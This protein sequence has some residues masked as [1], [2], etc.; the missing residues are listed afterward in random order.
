[1]A[2]VEGMSRKTP[3]DWDAIATVAKNRI[4]TTRELDDL[5]VP[6]KTVSDRTDP[7]GPWRRLLPGVIQ[8]S[9]GHLTTEQRYDAAL[10]YGGP[11]AVLTG[12]SAARL[13]GLQHLPEAAGVHILIPHRSRCL[14]SRFVTI[15]RTR[16]L[17]APDCRAGFAV[18]PLVRAVLDAARRFR[19]LDE[20]RA[21]LAEAVQRGL[22]KPELLKKEL[23]EGSG[24]GTRLP[25]MVLDEMLANV[26]SAAE[27]WAF[28]LA[29][30]SGLPPMQWNVRLLDSSGKLLGIPDGWI[31][32]VGL[33]W[34]ID[35]RAYHLSPTSYDATVQRHS[36]MTAAGII[37]VHT[38]PTQLRTD[39]DTVLEQLRG[40]YRLA[41]HSAHEG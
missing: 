33:A 22:V 39:P 27:G 21:L 41:G 3:I 32:E 12:I 20:V 7:G 18:A 19:E 2:I 34:Q 37:V 14:S 1:M 13:G 8:L 36:M 23:E 38:L 35:S 24:R 9:T 11:E 25:R 10:R 29:E 16:R 6:R 40:A 30:R 5:G 31:D 28:R 26:H 15:E 17:P 4:I